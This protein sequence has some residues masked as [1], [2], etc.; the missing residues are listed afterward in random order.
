MAA[1]FTKKYN[2]RPLKHRLLCNTNSAS[3]NADDADSVDEN[4]VAFSKEKVKKWLSSIPNESFS[5]SKDKQ[6]LSPLD[7]IVLKFTEET[8][9]SSYL[10]FETTACGCPIRLTWEAIHKDDSIYFTKPKIPSCIENVLY[11]TLISKSMSN[12]IRTALIDS[13]HIGLDVNK[14]LF[15]IYLWHLPQCELVVTR[16]VI[17]DI[18]LLILNRFKLCTCQ[19]TPKGVCIACLE[20]HFILNYCKS[21]IINDCFK[22]Q[23]QVKSSLSDKLNDDD[24]SNIYFREIWSAKMAFLCGSTNAN[25]VWFQ[26]INPHGVWSY[27]IVNEARK[28]CIQA[29][30]FCQ[31][32]K[33]PGNGAM[34]LCP[35]CTKVLQEHKNKSISSLFLA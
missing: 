28:H 15:G 32:C 3:V 7:E 9:C 27:L 18:K 8:N 23:I 16:Y 10:P 31:W 12:C 19:V 21:S 33:R 17:L 26:H 24:Q 14:A 2:L 34:F 11:G 1:F 35:S 13:K 22:I 5:P 25:K 20:N 6:P 30:Y 4:E 29:T